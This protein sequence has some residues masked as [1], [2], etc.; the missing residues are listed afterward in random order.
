MKKKYNYKFKTL[1]FVFGICCLDS[2]SMLN[3]ND[4]D[5][6]ILPVS[7]LYKLFGV[8]SVNSLQDEECTKSLKEINEIF[9]FIGISDRPNFS[10]ISKELLLSHH[11]HLTHLKAD[12]DNA[13]SD[14]NEPFAN[15]QEF[16]NA[17]MLI[18]SSGTSL[19]SPVSKSAQPKTQ[20]QA[21]V[22]HPAQASAQPQ[23]P[24][25]QP[26]PQ[27]KTQ[28]DMSV[29]TV[30]RVGS[31]N[32]CRAG[33][34]SLFSKSK[35]CYLPP[36]KPSCSGQNEESFSGRTEQDKKYE[37]LLDDYKS[38][39]GKKP[40]KQAKKDAVS[41]ELSSNS[42]LESSS[43]NKK[44]CVDLEKELLQIA[45]PNKRLEVLLREYGHRI[46]CLN[47][48]QEIEVL[49]MQKPQEIVQVLNDL[50][51][52]LNDR[53]KSDNIMS[54]TFLD[55][56][57]FVRVN[58]DDLKNFVEFGKKYKKINFHCVNFFRIGAFINGKHFEKFVPKLDEMMK[59]SSLV[60]LK[61]FFDSQILHWVDGTKTPQ[62]YNFYQ[63]PEQ[64][65]SFMGPSPHKKEQERV[66]L[67]VEEVL[68][69][70]DWSKSEGPIDSP[71]PAEP[72]SSQ[73]EIVRAKE[74][75]LKDIGE[76]ERKEIELLQ[77]TQEISRKFYGK[78][79]DVNKMIKYNLLSCAEIDELDLYLSRIS[80]KTRSLVIISVLNLDLVS[81]K[82]LADMIEKYVSLKFHLSFALVDLS[83]QDLDVLDKKLHY[84]LK[85]LPEKN[86]TG[87]SKEEILDI[88]L[89]SKD[90]W[91]LSEEEIKADPEISEKFNFLIEVYNDMFD[92]IPSLFH[93]SEMSRSKI[94]DN[95]DRLSSAFADIWTVCEN[96]KFKVN[97][98]NFTIEQVEKLANMTKKYSCFNFHL[99]K[100]FL[101][102]R[103][104][105]LDNIDRILDEMLKNGKLSDFTGLSI[106]DDENFPDPSYV[107]ESCD[108]ETSHS[109]APNQNGTEVSKEGA[110]DQVVETEEQFSKILS[111]FESNFLHLK[112]FI[113]KLG[114]VNDD[115]SR[116]Q[117]SLEKICN[118]FLESESDLKKCSI[119]LRNF[120]LEDFEKLANLCEKY[121]K[122]KFHC[123]EALFYNDLTRKDIN[124]LEE[125]LESMLKMEKP[126]D[127]TGCKKDEIVNFSFE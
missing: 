62:G 43:D 24:V 14:P 33:S 71:K 116:L 40:K 63:E 31:F 112:Y 5:I 91:P 55:N 107:V 36:I 101:A 54:V 124:V 102:M 44:R 2:V 32:V 66:P 61:G 45:E 108:N 120:S 20:P 8:E 75:L 4:V 53:E 83:K 99:S 100:D 113:D 84:V 93:F 11:V 117:S 52:L 57:K 122:L 10:K 114:R 80:E 90:L 77:K 18:Y 22:S 49:L 27:P 37:T 47:L 89:P 95:F 7:N 125:K 48:I 60:N 98:T 30:Y 110:K 94:F 72:A 51:E 65:V 38:N 73:S 29:C 82:K 46:S 39:T 104:E 103:A 115:F 59:S 9:T 12:I 15:M 16:V 42:S 78:F 111:Q 56:R 88:E 92:G 96:C 121:K 1:F 79:F 74:E 67:R 86:L 21:P 127:L 26:E 81:V 34:N 41:S 17:L 118:V 126:C 6:Q 28:K 97:I 105:N 119:S 50:V 13:E 23:A 87:L 3:E 68:R 69:N 76:S 25:S 106:L 58:F 19:K 123:S 85:F 109:G 64:E 35:N 70:I